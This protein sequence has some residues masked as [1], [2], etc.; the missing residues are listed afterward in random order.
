MF[1]ALHGIEFIKNVKYVF[2]PFIIVS[3]ILIFLVIIP[4]LLLRI[5]DSELL[6]L[7]DVI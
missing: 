6:E 3:I 7:K 5:S 2:L 1:L 4:N